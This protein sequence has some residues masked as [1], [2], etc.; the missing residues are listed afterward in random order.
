M[1]RFNNNCHVVMSIRIDSKFCGLHGLQCY[2][3][4]IPVHS[5]RLSHSVRD[6][7]LIIIFFNDNRCNNEDIIFCLTLGILG[8]FTGGEN[9]CSP[10]TTLSI[11]SIH[12]DEQ[13]LC[14]VIL[15][16]HTISSPFKPPSI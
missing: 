15:Y 12:G 3:H 2:D 10:S 6:K 4:S 8:F 5:T 7:D 9:Q 1:P 14:F 11:V 16:C 13:P